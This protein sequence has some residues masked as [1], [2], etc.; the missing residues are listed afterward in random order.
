MSQKLESL[1]RSLIDMVPHL[2]ATVGMAIDTKDGEWGQV[3]KGR[4]KVALSTLEE[5]GKK[6]KELMEADSR[7]L[8]QNQIYGHLF[9][10]SSPNADEYEER[11]KRFSH[12][13]ESGFRNEYEYHF[14]AM[15]SIAES[16]KVYLEKNWSKVKDWNRLSVS[17]LDNTG[18]RTEYY[19]NDLKEEL[20]TTPI[21]KGAKDSEI[22]DKMFDRLDK[23]LQKKHNP[24]V[25]LTG[26]VLDHSDG[27][28]SVCINGH[29]HNWI[30]DVSII[31]LAEYVE[32]ELK[33]QGEA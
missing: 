2:E 26:M 22:L 3:H 33:N 4:A 19:N 11:V 29:W 14:G 16:A 15:S 6:A 27:D 7:P 18:D 9:R 32:N 23:Y 8:P 28:F 10:I 31:I 21:S 25:S 17:I 30:D 5:W 12:H 13:I 24:V 1:L 20:H